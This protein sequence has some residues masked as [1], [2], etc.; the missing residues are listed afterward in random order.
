M[1]G[2]DLYV[3]EARIN[4]RNYREFVSRWREWGE[5]IARVARRLLGEGTRVFVFGSAVKGEALPGSDLDVL[6]VS[7]G[8]PEDLED[9]V[10]L[11]R[12]FERELD[13]PERHPIEFHLATPEEYEEVWRVLLDEYEEF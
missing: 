4:R 8:V 1:S 10:D 2:R 5:R 7:D 6:I 11:I 12:E 9:R 3:L 13:L